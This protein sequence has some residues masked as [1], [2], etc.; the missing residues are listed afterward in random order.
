MQT[1]PG[2]HWLVAQSRKM[3]FCSGLQTDMDFAKKNGHFISPRFFNFSLF[4]RFHSYL[5]FTKLKSILS[6]KSKKKKN[7]KET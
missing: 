2:P 3:K 7:K 6:E 4:F 1:G 5:S